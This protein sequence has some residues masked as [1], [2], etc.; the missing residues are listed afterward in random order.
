MTTNLHSIDQIEL[1]FLGNDLTSGLAT[2]TVI[3]ETINTDEFTDT[4]RARGS[5]DT[6]WNPDQTGTVAIVMAEESQ[7]HQT[8]IAIANAARDPGTRGAQIGLLKL[9]NNGNGTG[10]DWVNAKIMSRA[11]AV[12]GT[13]TQTVTWTFSF[14][15]G[16]YATADPLTSLVGT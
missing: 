4:V 10:I 7:A 9:Q 5:V 11:P 12:Y 16:D 13:E 3:T 2:G 1:D 14:E 6:A 15:R 8:L